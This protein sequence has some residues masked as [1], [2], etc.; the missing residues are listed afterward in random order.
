MQCQLKRCFAGLANQL[1]T[2]TVQLENKKGAIEKPQECLFPLSQTQNALMAA[3]S[4]EH[5]QQLSAAVPGTFVA[6]NPNKHA[7]LFQSDW[8]K[9]EQKV[10]HTPYL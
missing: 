10:P 2:D 5:P 1:A 7:D 3:R 9:W 4:M 6:S 8:H